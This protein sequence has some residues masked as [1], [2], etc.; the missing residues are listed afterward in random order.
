MKRRGQPKCAIY[1]L[2]NRAFA[3]CKGRWG[4]HRISKRYGAVCVAVL[5]MAT[6]PAWHGWASDDSCGIPGYLSDVED[7]VGTP[8]HYHPT[9][10][11]VVYVRDRSGDPGRGRATRILLPPA[12][13]G[14]HTLRSKDRANWIYRRIHTHDESG[15]LHVEPRPGHVLRICDLLKLWRS[16]DREFRSFSELEPHKSVN[17][18]LGDSEIVERKVDDLPT[19]PLNNDHRIIILVEEGRMM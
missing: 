8:K 12:N 7:T 5:L 1:D 2:K 10:A 18:I 16:A 17:V 3:F 15:V 6:I 4:D 11:I 9:V 14:I 19:I 13:L